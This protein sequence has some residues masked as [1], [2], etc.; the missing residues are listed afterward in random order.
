MAVPLWQASISACSVTPG[1]SGRTIIALSS[2]S[3][4]T[5][6]LLKSVGRIVSSWLRAQMWRQND[7]SAE[8]GCKERMQVLMQQ[9]RA[10]AGRQGKYAFSSGVYAAASRCATQLRN[11]T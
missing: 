10:A 2:S 9:I 8:I 4:M 1:A 3:T 7:K 11:G 6:A 5:P